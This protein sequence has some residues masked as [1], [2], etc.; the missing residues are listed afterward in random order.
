MSLML[1]ITLIPKW[2]LVL[3]TKNVR[4]V[5]HLYSKMSQPDCVAHQ[6]KCN[7]REIET[8]PEPLQGL[9]IGKDPD[10]SM[11]VKS[12]RTFNSCFQMTSLGATEIVQNNAANGQ[13]FNSTFKI[14][15]GL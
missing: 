14:K 1:N 10:S 2:T 15:G 7:Y 3:W 4:T 8:P 5:M 12:I 13:Q 9:L 6:E 11:L